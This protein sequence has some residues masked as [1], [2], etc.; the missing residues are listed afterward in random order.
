[1]SGMNTGQM[2][3]MNLR[4]ILPVLAI[5][6]PLYGLPVTAGE[7]TELRV[8]ASV[9]ANCKI[10]QIQDINFGA[11]DPGQANNS[12]AEGHISFAC[13]RGVDYRMTV[14]HGENYD[15]DRS[16]RRMRGN[17]ADYLPYRIDNELVSGSG[18]GFSAP[19]NFRIQASVSGADYRDL[20]VAAYQDTLRITL[21]P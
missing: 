20:P 19:L 15:R 9:I 2:D 21:E 14:D 12:S 10:L 8:T 13:T 3:I 11:L 6:L 1:M 4:Q 18:T 17:A 7:T 16:S 5:A